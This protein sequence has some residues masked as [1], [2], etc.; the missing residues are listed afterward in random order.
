MLDCDGLAFEF[1]LTSKRLA[2]GRMIFRRHGGKIVFCGRFVAVARTI[3][4]LLAG[5]NRMPGRRFVTI[6]VMASLTWATLYCVVFGMFGHQ[7][8]ILETHYR[9]YADILLA[10]LAVGAIVVVLVLHRLVRRYE[11]SLAQRRR[12]S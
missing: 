4:A 9:S 6:H 7:V 5:A 8:K 1:G 10:I 11:A 2:T 3:A 12:R